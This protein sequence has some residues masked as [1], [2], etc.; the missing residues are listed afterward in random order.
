MAE[1]V[2][3]VPGV[4]EA[5]EVALYAAL[6]DELP[7]QPLFEALAATGCRRLLPRPVGSVLEF[8]AVEAWSE[9]VPG[10]YGVP[11]PPPER[12]ATAL[13]ERVVVI[14]PGVA[15][16]RAGHRLG[17]GGGHYDRVLSGAPFA[18]ARPGPLRLGAALHLQLVPAVPHDSRDRPVDAIVTERG[19]Y[20]ARESA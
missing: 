1:H 15:F 5:P 19:V 2:L 11:V 18:G 10:R 6:A 9:L 12:P 20:W 17:R 7:M 16:D 8:A 3:A 4:R 14:V 13:S